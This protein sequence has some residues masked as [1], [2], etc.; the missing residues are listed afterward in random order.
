[1]VVRLASDRSLNGRI[2]VWWSE[3][4]PL[5]IEWEIGVTAMLQNSL[6][7]RA[8]AA[9]NSVD[10]RQRINPFSNHAS[11]ASRTA[12]QRRGRRRNL[13]GA[14]SGLAVGPLRWLGDDA[15]GTAELPVMAQGSDA[16]RYRGWDDERVPVAKNRSLVGRNVIA[17]S[18]SLRRHRQGAEWGPNPFTV[19]RGG[20]GP[21]STTPETKPCGLS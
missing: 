10:V 4:L 3:D 8:N 2:V 16:G 17:C 19:S 13:A 11:A 5:L 1:M 14:T 21:A 20:L 6:P 18:R 15:G 12:R 7:P 9:H